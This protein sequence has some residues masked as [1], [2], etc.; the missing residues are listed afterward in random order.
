MS[1]QV[2]D[3]DASDRGAASVTDPSDFAP[4]AWK[5][6]TWVIAVMH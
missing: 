3:I 4:I 2:M 5:S 1:K 6:H